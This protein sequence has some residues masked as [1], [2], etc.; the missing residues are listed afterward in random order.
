MLSASSAEL[1]V[2]T[3]LAPYT[4]NFGFAEAAHLLR[5]TTMGATYTQ[6][7]ESIAMGLDQTV[8]TL[9]LIPETEHLPL[10]YLESDSPLVAIGET[11]VNQPYWPSSDDIN[12]RK[13]SLSAWGMKL[14][15]EDHFSIREKMTLFWHNHFA[16][17][18]AKVDDPKFRYYYI[19]L[20]RDNCLGNFRQ[21]VKDVSIDPGMLFYLDGSQN[22]H[23]NPNEN[24]ARELLELFTIGKGPSADLGDYTNYT[25][26]DVLALAKV[27]T[28]WQGIG[29]FSETTNIPYGYFNTERHDTSDKQLSHRFN[30]VVIPNMEEEEYAHAIDIIFQ[31]DEVAYFISRKFYRYFVNY[32]LEPVEDTVIQEMAELLLE[33][34]YDIIELVR[35]LLKSQHFYDLNMRG[36]IIKNPLEF[37]SS[38][39]R[40]FEVPSL[41]GETDWY[42]SFSKLDT[43]MDAMGMQMFKPPNVAGW[44]AYYLGPLFSDHWINSVTIQPRQFFVSKIAQTGY[45]HDDHVF[46]IE[47]LSFIAQLPNATDPN[48]LITGITSLVF[49]LPISQEQVDYLKEILLPGIPD[50]EWTLEYTEYL[51]NPEDQALAEGITTRLRNLIETILSMPE[52]H[53]I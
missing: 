23:D 40:Q 6:I 30:N 9:L 1:P 22:T 51:A 5:R 50:F 47:P 43:R 25:E 27:F 28:G 44:P 39:M 18:R 41:N 48:E 31:Q 46:Q 11:W 32:D 49:A 14:L 10:N 24:F 42:A 35:A 34:D 26:E 2:T 4:G 53:I 15:L 29:R 3:G 19:S 37:V 12:N 7:Q 36:T 45:V 52:F 21:L 8:E 38:I 33:H 13:N 17:E 20:L 16:I